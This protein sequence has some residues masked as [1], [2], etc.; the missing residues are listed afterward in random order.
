MTC[1]GTGKVKE[2]IG[3]MEVDVSCSECNG[4]GSL[5]QACTA[6]NGKGFQVRKVKQNI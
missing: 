6:C 5:K 3:E 1:D 2:F 4:F